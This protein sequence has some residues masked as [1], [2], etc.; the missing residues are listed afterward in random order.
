MVSQLCSLSD[1]GRAGELV[2]RKQLLSS[3]VTD[4]IFSHGTPN[5]LV[6]RHPAN[7]GKFS[8]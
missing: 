2:D 8:P 6:N 5:I 4:M 1:L 3:D 7:S